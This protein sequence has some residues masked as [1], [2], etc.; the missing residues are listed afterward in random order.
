MNTQTH[1]AVPPYSGDMVSIAQPLGVSLSNPSNKVWSLSVT[2][3]FIDGRPP[4]VG[5]FD[6]IKDSRPISGVAFQVL[7][8][9]RPGEMLA[10]LFIPAVSTDRGISVVAR[11]IEAQISVNAEG[12]AVQAGCRRL[13]AAIF[14]RSSKARS[15]LGLRL[16]NSAHP[17][18]RAIPCLPTLH[19]SIGILSAPSALQRPKACVSYPRADCKSRS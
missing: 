18:R 14:Q 5:V 8:H 9:P 11:D 3:L 19:D 2:V 10:I 17:F 1:H 12:S 15:T 4:S 7:P 16:P 13:V 6:E